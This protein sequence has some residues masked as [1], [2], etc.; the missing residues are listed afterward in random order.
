MPVLDSL[1]KRTF[2]LLTFEYFIVCWLIISLFEQAFSKT[3]GKNVRI[4]SQTC[5]VIIKTSVSPKDV[6]VFH[7][8]I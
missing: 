1:F 8:K 7:L 4:M 3:C 2:L 6:V 5:T